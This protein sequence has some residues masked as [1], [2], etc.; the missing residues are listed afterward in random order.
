MTE[1]NQTT[2]ALTPG[3]QKLVEAAAEKRQQSNHPVLSAFHWLLALMERHAPM[4]ERLV[5]GIEATGMRR[6]LY[7]Q[8]R[9]GN[10]GDPLEQQTVTLRADERAGRRGKSQIAE[11]DLAFVIL[12]AAGY[13][14]AEEAVV[15]PPPASPSANKPD[16]P[17]TAATT[18]A[19]T[20]SYR[21]VASK[22]TP[23]LEQYGRDLTREAAEG[24]LGAFVGRE[25]EIQLAIETLCR[26]TK[27]NP[28]LVGPAGVGKTAIVEGLA[29]RIVRGEVP[30]LLKGSRLISIQPSTLV[31]GAGIMGEIEKRM[32]AIIE[33]AAQ[34]GVL[35]FIDEIH[36]IMGAG[37]R[38]GTSDIASQLKPVLA[39]GTLA[40]IAA[41]TDEEYRRFIET[42][43]ALERRFQPI[44]VQ[45]LNARQTLV[46]IEAI[47]DGYARRRGV[48]VPDEVLRWL[49]DF[50]QDFLRNRYFPDKAV[51]LLEQ[52]VANA[53]ANGKTIVDK[54]AAE[55]VAQRV[56]GMPISLHERQDALRER[57]NNQVLLIE[58]DVTALVNRLS[59]TM[60]G[61]D[62][63]QQRPNAVILLMGDATSNSEAL[64]EA[65]AEALFGARER[66]VTIDFSRFTQAHDVTM[67]IGAPP[68]YI[69]YSESL[70]MH[71]VAQMPWCVLR[72]ENIHACHPAVREVLTQALAEGFLTESRGKRI[73]LSD[74]VVL[75]TAD[76]AP[77]ARRKPG[78]GKFEE[79]PA[80][81][82]RAA[83][84]EYLGDELVAQADIVCTRQLTSE[85]VQRRWIQQSLLA[86]IEDRYRKQGI[87]LMWDP[88]FIEWLM[89]Q[90]SSYSNQREWE[91]LVDER[92]SP[93]I[94]THL[95][96]GVKGEVKT[97]RVRCEDDRIKIDTN[98]VEERSE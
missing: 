73:Y 14:P 68:G 51:D 38:E 12:T 85:E 52:C 93:L 34:K 91:R 29:Q 86:D 50:A 23:T 95:A 79:S 25:E 19:A 64:A 66:V 37:G 45:E 3:A 28:V 88:S 5:A 18:A 61:L 10:A 20:T 7:E 8:L 9:Q 80:T 21:P 97:L 87:E 83:A 90:R 71:R 46:V 2:R 67:L 26:E 54:A 6:H 40:C 42:D 89:K 31:A 1:E 72:C 13:T 65:I 16:A 92:F 75:L 70:P 94:V 39:R 30:E 11:A 44:R 76:I 36:S 69:G 77:Q 59:V 49:V 60:R 81:S 4:A 15:Q 56:V 27:R 57:L 82:E 63:R 17:E 33:E 24:K 32:K 98:R 74:T 62:L 22:P 84:V 58:E 47:R 78:F 43:S 53:V 55:A 35:L 48:E 41:T 96:S